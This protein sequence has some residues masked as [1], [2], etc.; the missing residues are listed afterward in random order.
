MKMVFLLV[1]SLFSAVS[2]AK[3][4]I[5]HCD[6]NFTESFT[7][8]ADYGEK[9]Q[10][11][12]SHDFDDLEED[13]LYI[14]A[15]NHDSHSGKMA[16]WSDDDDDNALFYDLNV[17]DDVESKIRFDYEPLIQKDSDDNYIGSMTYYVKQNGRW[18]NGV[19]KKIA[20]NYHQANVLFTRE[21]DDND[22]LRN[23]Q[24]SDLA[25]P[26]EGPLVHYEFGVLEGMDC[27]Y[28]CNVLFQNKYKN[29]IV[30][31]MSTIDPNNIVDSVP[32]KSSVARVW[33]SK[34][35]ATIE[36]ES[37][38]GNDKSDRMSPIYY[39]VTEPG[40]LEFKDHQGHAIYGEAGLVSS[41]KSQCTDKKNDCDGWD[42][43]SFQH[44]D[45]SNAVIMAQVQGKDK[46]WATTAISNISQKGFSLALERGRQ[47]ALPKYSSKNIAYMAISSFHGRDK[48]DQSNVE[49]YR[50]SREYNQSKELKDTKSIGWSC[51]NNKVSLHQ[52]FNK[53]GV[54][55]NKQSRVGSHGGWLRYCKQYDDSATP[56]FTFAFDE[57]AGSLKQRKHGANEQIGYFAF[58]LPDVEIPVATVCNLF[59]EPIQSWSG[60]KSMLN[61]TNNSVRFTGWSQDYMTKYLKNKDDGYKL[62]TD[63]YTNEKEF[64]LLGFDEVDDAYQIY[65]NPVC[66]ATQC[67]V[68]NT[69]GMLHLRKVNGSYV[70]PVPV[71]NTS[72]ELTLSAQNNDIKKLCG[73]GSLLCSFE[74]SGSN[75]D[76]LIKNNLSKLTINKVGKDYKLLRV[77]FND[78]VYISDVAV[79]N[80]K[81]V[82]FVFAENSEVTFDTYHH[83][84]GN[85]SYIFHNGSRIN[86]RT[87]MVFD[88]KVEIVSDFGYPVIY[89]PEASVI[90]NESGSIF[91]GFILADDLTLNST[92]IQGAVTVKNGKFISNTRIDKPDY[93]C[94]L[95]VEPD[96]ARIEIKPFNYH[97]TCDDK[98][99]VEVHSFDKEGELVAGYQPSL[100]ETD[101]GNNL[102]F[103]FVSE[104]GGIAKYKVTKNNASH[105]GN[106]PVTASLSLASGATLTDG[107]EIKYVPYKFEVAD[108]E[109][110]AGQNNTIDIGVQACNQDGKLITLGYQGKPSTRFTYKQPITTS[111][112]ND[113]L[114]S[115]V[116][117]DTNRT[118][119][120]TFMESG[121]ITVHIEDK[122][123]VCNDEE[124]CPV[125]GGG[126]LKGEFEVQSRPYKLAICDVKEVANSANINPNTT[127]SGRGFMA[128]GTSFSVTYKP[129]V[130][131]ESKGAVTDECDYP[132]TGNYAL[133][134]GPI[135][136]DN[137]LAYPSGGVAGELLPVVIPAYSVSS[138]TL[139]VIHTW[140]EVGTLA[141]TSKATYLGKDLMVDTQNVGRFYPSYFAIS[142]SDWVAPIDQGG[143]TYL[144]QPFASAVIRVASFA[145]GSTEPLQ[146]YHHFEEVLQA[147]FALTEEGSAERNKLVIDGIENI[148][149]RENGGDSHWF[150]DTS[151]AVVMRH[152]LLSNHFSLTTKE[153]GPFNIDGETTDYGL[154]ISGVDPVSFDQD[155]VVVGQAFLHQPALRYGRMVLGSSGGQSGKDLLVPLRVEYWNGSQFILNT[156]D[157]HSKLDSS[158]SYVCKQTL[159][160]EGLASDSQLSGA[161]SSTRVTD[162]EFDKLT[163]KADSD[164]DSIREQVRFWLRLD[165]TAATGHTSPQVSSSGVTCGMNST[166]QPWLQYNWSGLGDEDP[167]TVATFGIFRGNDK[168][169]FRGES[170][171]IGL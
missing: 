61:V 157:S 5:E 93:S 136:L 88:P 77:R 47:G 155:T 149:W 90:F 137:T 171:L 87:S 103:D 33:D 59:P 68:G 44:G 9:K 80:G 39:F 170:G 8:T 45:I 130:H 64:L 40:R 38:P 140:S 129:I 128:A 67:D 154:N 49:F 4:V 110:V 76:V 32:T 121:V 99:M 138:P 10:R 124:R 158:A 141:L 31:L 109:I 111:N 16:L 125:F 21:D 54:I 3:D 112:D 34:Q 56:G 97:L 142:Q 46:D 72:Q 30:F 24:C 161:A 95:P 134:K 132:L 160:S 162:G 83:Q 164:D 35:G 48:Y 106:Y 91:K 86:A 146:N 107:N 1:L 101:D 139:T 163:A 26:P 50:G 65:N 13:V 105:L 51:E 153:N 53:F 150:V 104:S 133:D 62:S 81:E 43:V 22:E 122:D 168:I 74:V 144:S 167:S 96:V 79:S 73:E 20:T 12:R 23:L 169:I 17:D 84:S 52:K 118:A 42:A 100:V 7:I 71:R 37:A 165:D 18:S 135:K 131:P 119:P 69:D 116:L 14:I 57:D 156:D 147:K 126:A 55:A 28:G 58:E 2:F 117:S 85:L 159:W 11:Y 166:A 29:P 25:Q 143:V 36:S 60:Q 41:S 120:L 148:E 145:Y 78:G 63:E 6:V 19:V 15:K 152:E 127:S 123:F 151:T 75:V 115:P 114:F 82:E 94:A 102:S 108:Q 113:L 92:S 27:T 89:A 70:E 98:Q 66:N